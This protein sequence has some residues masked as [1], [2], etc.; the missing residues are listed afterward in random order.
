MSTGREKVCVGPRAHLSFKSREKERTLLEVAYL[1][2]DGSE[3]YGI[4][5][6]S[7]E[8][9]ILAIDGKSAVLLVELDVAERDDRSGWRW[10]AMMIAKARRPLGTYTAMWV[11]R[12]SKSL[13]SA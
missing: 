6:L 12:S 11:L 7:V 13:S 3:S 2:L 1:S 8:W 10:S 4:L 9:D 5:L